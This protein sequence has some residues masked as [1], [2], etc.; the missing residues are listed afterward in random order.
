MISL[1]FL[2][3]VPTDD[4]V[5]SHAIVLPPVSAPI[6][7]LLLLMLIQPHIPFPGITFPFRPS[8]CP[9]PLCDTRPVRSTCPTPSPLYSGSVLPVVG[10]LCQLRIL[11]HFTRTP[12]IVKLDTTLSRPRKTLLVPLC[13]NLG[14]HSCASL[15]SA[16]TTTPRAPSISYPAI[17]LRAT[18]SN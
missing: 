1:T 5:R 10:R 4:H 9:I 15:P 12:L 6:P 3:F 8:L 7:Y 2:I 18:T 11:P 13:I 17:R 16:R 14:T